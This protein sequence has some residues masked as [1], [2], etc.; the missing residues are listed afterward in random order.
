MRHMGVGAR[1]GGGRGLRWLAPA[2]ARPG[3]LGD[4]GHGAGAD[5]AEPELQRGG[6]HPGNGGRE[7]LVPGLQGLGVLISYRIH[8][9]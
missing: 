9:I 1:L 6:P 8:S 4:Q 3:D 2:G 7:G 5:A